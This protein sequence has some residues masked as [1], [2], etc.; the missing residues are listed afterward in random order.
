[1]IARLT[2]LAF[3]CIALGLLLLLRGANLSGRGRPL[4]Q[5]LLGTVLVSFGLWTWLLALYLVGSR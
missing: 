1:M 2:V 5:G 3:V 4:L